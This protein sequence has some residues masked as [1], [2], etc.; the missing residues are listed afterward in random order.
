MSLEKIEALEER[1]TKVVEMVKGLKEENKR[2]D[3][4]L[5]NEQLSK[6]E[7]EDELAKLRQEKEQV[8]DR[9]ESILKGIEDITGQ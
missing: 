3:S 2:L 8:K 7:L 9:L 4:E 1:I 6:M 5:Q